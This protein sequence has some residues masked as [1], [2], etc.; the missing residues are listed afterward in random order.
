MGGGCG[1]VAGRAVQRACGTLGARGRPKSHGPAQRSRILAGVNPRVGRA[2]NIGFAFM[3]FILY[4]N[5]LS[6]GKTWIE[7]GQVPMGVFF[8]ALHGGIFLLATV[9]LLKRHN[10]WTWLRARK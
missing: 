3:A 8:V 10:G 5:F 1:L 4:F 2:A 6:L 9:L 7:S